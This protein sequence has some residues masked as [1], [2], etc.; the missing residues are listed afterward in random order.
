GAA[1]STTISASGSSSQATKPPSGAVIE[2]PLAGH[3]E[4][5]AEL[6]SERG[7]RVVPGSAFDLDGQPSRGVR[8]SLTRASVDRIEAG[9]Q[10]LGTAAAELIAAPAAMRNFL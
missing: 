7:V 6:A 1:T 2:Q 3:G 4:R 9:I 5:L 10:V 8:L